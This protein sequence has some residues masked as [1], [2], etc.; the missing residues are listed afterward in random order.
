MSA[1][2]VWPLEG[3]AIGAPHM[4]ADSLADRVIDIQDEVGEVDQHNHNVERWWGSNGAATETNAIAATV[5]VPFQVTSG[6]DDWGTAVPI[7]GTGD[8]PVLSGQTEFDA[9]RLIVTDLDDQTDPWRVRI[10]WGSGTSAAAISAGQWSEV[11]II[12]NAVPGNRAGGAPVDVRMPPI[13][14]GLKMWAQSWNDTN[15]EVLSFFWG[16]HGYPYP[17]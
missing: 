3:V 8:N 9:H 10:I 11:I 5:T 13:A 4:V 1:T 12:A 15:N 7:C 17:P 16:A 6:N 2:E 14:I